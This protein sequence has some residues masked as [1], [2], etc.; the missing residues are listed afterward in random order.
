MLTVRPLTV[1]MSLLVILLLTDWP[2]LGSII[3]I[4]S[5]LRHVCLVV[6]FSFLLAMSSVRLSSTT[7]LSLFG[8]VCAYSLLAVVNAQN[9]IFAYILGFLFTFIFYF[10]YLCGYGTL[11]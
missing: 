1:L 4:P 11:S 10:T 7:S 6:F 8:I 9:G 5:G 3:A 2:L